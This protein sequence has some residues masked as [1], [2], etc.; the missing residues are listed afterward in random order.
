MRNTT[1][2]YVL[3]D[4][5]TLKIRYVGKSNKPQERYYDHINNKRDTNI[6]KKNWVNKLKNENLKPI[7]EVIDEVPIDTWK[8]YEKMYIK[9]YLDEGCKLMNY[10]KGGDGGTF[11]NKTSFKIGDGSKKIVILNK[12]GDFIKTFNSI[13]EAGCELK[14]DLGG[15]CHTLNKEQKSCANYLFLYEDEYLTMSSED[16]EKFVKWS[17]PKKTTSNVTSYKEKKIFQYDLNK[18]FIKKWNSLAEASKTLDIL[19]SSICQCAKNKNKTGG[20]FIWSYKII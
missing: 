8:L 7:I 13:T 3:K 12:N 10:T 1:F 18:N 4:P 6:H 19:T 16:I 14:R 9:K 17:I 5:I 20:G 15:I 2:I 11:A